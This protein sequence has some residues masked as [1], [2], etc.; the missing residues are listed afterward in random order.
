MKGRVACGVMLGGLL[1]CGSGCANRQVRHAPPKREVPPPPERRPVPPRPVSVPPVK[2]H[3]QALQTVG[4]RQFAVT[5][6]D[7]ILQ[8]K[9]KGFLQPAVRLGLLLKMWPQLRRCTRVLKR[10]L[11]H[12]KESFAFKVWIGPQGHLWKALFAGDV[13]SDSRTIRCLQRVFGR[14]RYPKPGGFFVWQAQVDWT[15]KPV[16]KR[17]VARVR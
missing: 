9:K 7:R 8:L 14:T 15:K 2:R 11:P 17:P 13:T 10:R 1:L 3:P 16:V 6:V 12:V 5:Q 4:S